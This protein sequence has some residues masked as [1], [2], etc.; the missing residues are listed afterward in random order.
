M[1]RMRLLLL[2]VLISL[3]SL[4][5]T[6]LTADQLKGPAA[7]DHPI[8]YVDRTVLIAV[9]ARNVEH[10]LPTFFGYLE[11]QEY[12]KSRISLWIHSDHNMDHTGAVL[13]EW[14]AG[15]SGDYHSIKLTLSDEWNIT[16]QSNPWEWTPQRNVH[17]AT[18]RQSAL[19]YALSV[20]ADYI[21]FLDTD[22]FLCDPHTLSDLVGAGVRGV[23]PF[24]TVGFEKLFSN[25]W[26][27]LSDTGYY[28]R[29]DNYVAILARDVIGTFRV[30]IIHS[31]VLLDLRDSRVRRLRYWPSPPNYDQLYPA[32]EDTLIL[33]LS[34]AQQGVDLYVTNQRIYGHMILP[35][36]FYTREHAIQHFTDF[37]LE[38]L[39]DFPPIPYS[40]YITQPPVREPDTLGVDKIFVINLERRPERRERMQAALKLLNLQYELFSA[41][42]GR[43]LNE[44]YLEEHNVT[45]L[46]G[47]RDPWGSRPI[48]NGEIG[49]F[50][51]HYF[52]W[53]KVVDGE[54]DS[55]MVIED[56]IRFLSGFRRRFSEMLD[57][58]KRLSLDWDLI[59]LG[60]KR[61][62]RSG[63]PF[64]SGASH[65]VHPAYTYWT[66]GYMLSLSGAKKLLAQQPLGKIMAVDEYL[67]VMFDK[68]P[69]R[70]WSESF[71]PRDLKVY[72]VEPLVLEPTHFVGDKYY[73]TDTE[74]FTTPP[75]SRV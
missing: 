64:V 63:E 2:C 25:F 67:P 59:Y 39:V 34:A 12:T 51:S 3:L 6:S 4:H 28:Q 27:A 68:H 9:L 73:F 18:L 22:V 54:M 17:V 8:Q 72:S 7:G 20:W 29:S 43:Q 57:E 26:G 11:R 50:L 40:G 74:P 23:A 55:V 65:L 69:R 75:S 15:A 35:T 33:L 1:I 60:R 38:N 24:L 45:M 16:D 42:D 37:S 19:D 41:I 71:H 14:T 62:V 49:C 56:D 53:E 30:P 36:Q 46:P 13:R 47:W 52:I 31:S 5:T 58:V 32:A 21:W 10:I 44:S 48:T 66:V 70:D 61:L